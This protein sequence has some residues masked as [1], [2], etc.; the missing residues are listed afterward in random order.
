MKRKSM[1]TAKQKKQMDEH[2][3]HHT[4]KHMDMMRNLMNK[5]IS[6]KAAHNKAMKEVGR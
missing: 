5:G 3:D 2:K 6:F 4:K 1:M